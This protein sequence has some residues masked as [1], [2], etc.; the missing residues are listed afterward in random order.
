MITCRVRTL[1]GKE[2][3]LDIEPDYKVHT[4]LLHIPLPFAVVPATVCSTLSDSIVLRLNGIKT[5]RN[6]PKDFAKHI[7]RLVPG[8]PDKGARRRE[9]GY[10]ACSTTANFRRKANVCLLTVYVCAGAIR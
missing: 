3:E 6:I 8:V 7:L 4:N 1:T 2:I 9:G 10:P 5:C